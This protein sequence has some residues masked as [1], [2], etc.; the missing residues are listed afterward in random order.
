MAGGCRYHRGLCS[1]HPPPL[2]PDRQVQVP[3]FSWSPAQ[4]ASCPC[5][6]PCS[7]QCK[8]QAC[9]AAGNGGVGPCLYPSLLPSAPKLQLVSITSLQR[10]VLLSGVQAPSGGRDGAA[11][12]RPYHQLG[13]DPNKDQKCLQGRVVP[14]VAHGHLTGTVS[15]GGGALLRPRP[16]AWLPAEWGHSILRCRGS[17]RKTKS[18]CAGGSGL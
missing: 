16:L 18:C 14:Q 4:A 9:K 10:S 2:L 12:G 8:C 1:H 5:P 6:C 15:A 11:R 13:A 3:G 7:W 17:K